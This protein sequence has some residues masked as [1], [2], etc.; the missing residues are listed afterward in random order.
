MASSFIS[1]HAA[2]DIRVT[3]FKGILP[4]KGNG[5]EKMD[6]GR[7]SSCATPS[8]L[9]IFTLF[10]IPSL[11]LIHNLYSQ[12]NG[13]G[14]SKTAASVGVRSCCHGRCQPLPRHVASVVRQPCSCSLPNSFGTF[15]CSGIFF[16]C[17][18]RGKSRP[19]EWLLLPP[20]WSTRS[21]WLTLR[22]Q[23]TPTCGFL[24][25]VQL[26]A[27]TSNLKPQQWLCHHF[28]SVDC[29]TISRMSETISG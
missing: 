24:I 8:F 1:M 11:R 5:K 14:N 16:Q 29:S 28:C 9:S 13:A 12:Q 17:D 18:G 15:C 10:P 22:A 6:R 21:S 3:R 2:V 25:R 27:L 19:A 7:E 26:Q 20:G 4:T 23:F